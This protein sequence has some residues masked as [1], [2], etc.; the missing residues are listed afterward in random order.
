MNG[1]ALCGLALA[2]G[3]FWLWYFYKKDRLEPE[4]KIL[5]LK[6]FFWG[7]VAVLPVFL[8]NLGCLAILSSLVSAM[9]ANFALAV[10][11]APFI[12]EWA[13][14][15]VVRLYIYNHIEF[16][17][18]MDGIVYAAAA[19]LGFASME[20]LGYVFSAGSGAQPIPNTHSI[21]GTVLTVSCFRAFLSV[22]GH[23][24]FSSM[25]GFALGVAKFTPDPQRQKAYIDMG[26]F[27]AMILHGI[28][29]LAAGLPLS[30]FTLL[31]FLFIA[32]RMVQKRITEALR[33]SP[34]AQ[35]FPRKL[36]IPD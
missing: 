32:W 13:K 3:M 20:N 12:E 29:N 14:Y 8:I 11:A 7:M 16:D 30:G 15:L 18:P 35:P 21:L 1:Y 24:L 6:T 19:A 5:V 17:E 36:S 28:F 4:P 26:L 31:I 33:N 2:P 9:P 22:P 25:W 27:L 34:H 10:F 23:V